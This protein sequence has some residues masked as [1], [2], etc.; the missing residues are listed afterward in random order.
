LERGSLV[1]LNNVFFDSNSSEIQPTSQSEIE[2]YAS[3]LKAHPSLV[4]EL[5]AHSVQ[6]GNT[7]TNLALSTQRAKAILQQFVN[8][9]IGPERIKA[10]GYGDKLKLSEGL[11]AYN[12]R[13]EF[14][15]VQNVK[16]GESIAATE[17]YYNDIEKE[18]NNTAQVM[19]ARREQ[20]LASIETEKEDQANFLGVPFERK[21]VNEE[22]TN[23][24][25]TN[26]SEAT[27]SNKSET[28][29]SKKAT[30]K[31]SKSENVTIRGEIFDN[32][33]GKKLSARV[34]LRNESGNV[35]K[36]ITTGNDG[37]YNFV[38]PLNYEKLFSVYAEKQG[39]NFNSAF[40]EINSEKDHSINKDISLKQLREGT[41]FLLKHVYYD[42]SLSSL[43]KESFEELDKL[44]EMLHENKD[45]R[46]EVIGHTDSHGGEVYNHVLSQSRAQSV[47][48]YLIKKGIAQN[49]IVAIGMGEQKPLASND[50]EEEGRELNRRTEILILKSK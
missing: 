35:L 47:K 43:R 37:K 14:I 20:L 9:G 27:I 44:L 31:S 3:F 41:K 30:S 46:L 12:D 48:S 13:I 1:V 16:P 10:V 18:K 4:V 19:E 36:E 28:S 40:L 22:K 26:S 15:V 25:E 8:L 29:D 33:T 38:T 32:A 11:T 5:A 6:G 2:K 42:I 50:D 17:G 23:A 49:R 39:Y 45:L 34:Q 7:E 24:I 21:K